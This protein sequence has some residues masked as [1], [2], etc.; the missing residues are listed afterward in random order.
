AIRDEAKKAD[1]VFLAPDPDR[2][3]EAIAQHLAE[4]ITHDA[5]SRIRFYEITKEGIKKALGEPGQIDALLV[6]AHKAR[7]VLDRL[8]GYKV[9]P[10]LWQMIRRGLSA[11]RVQSVA[12][13]I[14]SER[15]A[16]ID[17]FKPEPYWVIKG[18]FE[19]KGV[20][21]EAELAKIE[22]KRVERV[23]EKQMKAAKKILKKGIDLGVSHYARAEKHFPPPAPFKTST[24]Q[25]EASTVLR[26]AP[27][28]TMRIAQG[29]YEGVTLEETTVGLVT[30]MRT[31]SLRVAPEF[32]SSTAGFITQTMGAEWSQPRAYKD[33]KTAQAA[34]EAIRP[35]GLARS[36]EAIAGYLERDA[37]RLYDLI[38]RRYLASQMTDAR[39][40]STVAELAHSGYV[41]RVRTLER[42][43]E[44]YERV[45]SREDRETKFSLPEL[46]EGDTVK[47]IELNVER[48]QTQPPPRY[49]EASLVRKLE[50]YGIGRP[51]TYASI[52]GTLVE[53]HYALRER[54]T[55]FPTELGRL[56]NDIL[57]PRFSDLINVKFT[58]R[59]EEELDQIAVGKLDWQ[60]ALRDFWG[61][62][63]KDLARVEA[64]IPE[65]KRDVVKETGEDCPKCG[66]PLIEKWGRFGKFLACSGFPEC[67]Y[68]RPLKE[69][70]PVKVEKKCPE[71][72]AEMVVKV[73][74]YGRFLAC[75]RYPECKTTI[76]FILPQPCPL[77][78]SEVYE[79][80]GK[81]GKFYKCSNDD[82]TFT[83][84]YPLSDEKCERCG[85]H[86]VADPRGAYC[87]RCEP[88]NSKKKKDA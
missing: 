11:G 25:Q 33:K 57:V 5:V 14:L 10:L 4:E 63:S 45:Y 55:L 75:S 15:E 86:K 44:G 36:P 56:V 31:D 84:R 62:F 76:P 77:C 67:R 28:R 26:F 85:K 87:P 79:L 59:M 46:A 32:I 9:S 48:K 37:K 27:R 1:E 64:E 83:S 66:K 39:Y 40:E 49:T 8:V 30:Y 38:Y 51:S 17:A 50:A 60:Q 43:F 74:R 3:G 81:R 70:E 68:T 6:D 82:C 88:R 16:E 13:R 71:C 47:L 53:R 29:L 35:T 65:I 18:L 12:L 73:G 69:N 20:K 2:E 72:G 52:M 58:S 61:P 54:S 80:R 7:R 42:L 24:L 34:H 19:A 22:G 23:D 78:G 21:F 41:F